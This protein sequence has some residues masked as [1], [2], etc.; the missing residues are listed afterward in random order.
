M[1][2]KGVVLQIIRKIR[3]EKIL[4]DDNELEKVVDDAWSRLNP[5]KA[6]AVPFNNATA[7]II[8]STTGVSLEPMQE[9]EATLVCP[10]I[11]PD[12]IAEWINAYKRLHRISGKFLFENEQSR[13]QIIDLLYQLVLD[14]FE[15]K[16]L[17]R[18]EIFITGPTK[19]RDGKFEYLHGKVDFVVEDR[20]KKCVLIEAKRD[21]SFADTCQAIAPAAIEYCKTQEPVWAI[22]SNGSNWAFYL[23]D[24]NAVFTKGTV[25]SDLE[26]YPKD[27]RLKTALENMY[28]WVYYVF[29]TMNN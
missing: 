22:Y 6:V 1:Q 9:Q 26:N 29:K 28:R 13:R 24:K 12:W 3:D 17:L 23:V 20:N 16:F 25:L 2:M 10:E 11:Q 7:E 21:W 27:S 14:R 5:P 19:E 4:H 15:G 8:K 18:R